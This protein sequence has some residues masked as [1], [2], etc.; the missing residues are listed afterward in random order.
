MLLGRRNHGFKS[1]L[2][3]A[4]LVFRKHGI[5]FPSG[6]Q[7]VS[8]GHA[9]PSATY[10]ETPLGLD[11]LQ[12]LQVT[13]TNRTTAS[14]DL[15]IRYSREEGFRLA[16]EAIGAATDSERRIPPHGRPMPAPEPTKF[17]DPFAI[18][19]EMS[20]QLLSCPEGWTTLAEARFPDDEN[21]YPVAATDGERLLCGAPL[22]AL[23]IRRHW[24]PPMRHGY[25]ALRRKPV[26]HTV[27]LWLVSLIGSLAEARSLPVARLETWPSGFTSALTI[28]HDHDRP[29]EDEA[30]DQLLDFYDSCGLKAS[31]GFRTSLLPTSQIAKAAAAGHEITLHAETAD[32]RGL[33]REIDAIT[34]VTGIRPRGVT[35]HG[36]RGAV[37]HLGQTYFEAAEAA[38]MEHADILSR[39]NMYPHPAVIARR[40]CVES[41]GIMLTALH[42]S[43]DTGTAPDAHALHILQ[44]RVPVRL[45]E[46]Q[47]VTIMNHPDVHLDQ[48]RKLLMTLD[49]TRV[50]K[51]T[52]AT[53]VD[54]FRTVHYGADVMWSGGEIGLRFPRP[55]PMNV[56][57]HVGGKAY[58]IPAGWS[59]GCLSDL[60]KK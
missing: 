22:F 41:A 23:C 11:F 19:D 13:T 58:V 32:S 28:R 49:M 33:Q 26:P 43:L 42:N 7:I 55:V 53:A 47:H 17:Q 27:E 46:G 5:R 37:G 48:L 29:M 12:L 59:G 14:F 40:R 34:R 8:S 15:R 18:T 3:L 35:S 54:W 45:Q 44:E 25:Y 24:M 57:L 50:W 6:L 56:G 36:G 1:W 20:L 30:I 21:W 10:I 38:G 16:G 39:N 4:D 2:S 31:W 52:H 51:V 60:S 9:T